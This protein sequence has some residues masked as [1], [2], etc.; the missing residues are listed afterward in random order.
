MPEGSAA[1]QRD[2]SRMEK[3]ADRNLIK[4][5]KGK[6][7]ALPLGRN[8]PRHQHRLRATHLESSLSEKDLGIL[9]DTRF[10]HEPAMCPC[11]KEGEWYPELH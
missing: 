6:C 5:S 11:G 1:I 9:M 10:G 8:N 4:L 2:L 7:K 3:W